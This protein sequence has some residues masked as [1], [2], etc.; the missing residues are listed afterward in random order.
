[1]YQLIS[2]VLV[3]LLLT[4]IFVNAH[5]VSVIDLVCCIIKSSTASA[6]TTTLDM[7]FSATYILELYSA[8]SLDHLCNF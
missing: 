8:I 3:N 5:V 1:M 2:L 7:V 6:V 4:F